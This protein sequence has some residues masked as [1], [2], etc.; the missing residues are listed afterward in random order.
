MNEVTQRNPYFLL[1]LL[2]VETLVP[3]SDA[4]DT[5]TEILLF[6]WGRSMKSGWKSSQP[7]LAPDTEVTKPHLHRIIQCTSTMTNITHMVLSR[8]RIHRCFSKG[9]SPFSNNCPLFINHQSLHRDTSPG[10]KFWDLSFQRADADHSEG[11][12]HRPWSSP[13]WS[14]EIQ[15]D[16]GIHPNDF[17]SP[18]PRCF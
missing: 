10:T 15:W 13:R 14:L 1:Y 9:S 2:W 4:Q 17:R 3:L 6:G 8:N 5:S 11:Q 18:K 7:T 12:G 16:V